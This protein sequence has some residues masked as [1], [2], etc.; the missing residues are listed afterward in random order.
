MNDIDEINKSLNLK[1]AAE[2]ERR[3]EEWLNAAKGTDWTAKFKALS[4]E[5]SALRRIASLCKEEI[6]H[7]FDLP[8]EVFDATEYYYA[9]YGR[10]ATTELKEKTDVRS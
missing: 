5:V 9:K 6:D 1:V 8:S 7:G 2:V 3:A 4:K 10:P